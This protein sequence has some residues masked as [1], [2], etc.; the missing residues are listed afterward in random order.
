MEDM[1]M[2]IQ[3]TTSEDALK[4]AL[5]AF[6]TNL[7]TPVISGELSGWVR[8]VQKSWS[9]TSSQVHY[10]VKH[11]HPREFEEMGGADPELLPR[12]EQLEAEDAALEEDREKLST[13]ISRFVEHAPKLE[14]DEGKAGQHT[15]KLVDEGLAFIAR[16]RK[17]QVA[18]KTWFVEAFNRDRG[19]VD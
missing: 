3:D 12:I 5:E 16:V 19:A 13:A 9:E 15:K 11:L 18:I 6:E 2:T 7:A 1:A 17:Q 8:G 14:P 4:N 10:T